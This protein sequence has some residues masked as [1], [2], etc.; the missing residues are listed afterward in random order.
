MRKQSKTTLG[1]S[2]LLSLVLA[3][4]AAHSSSAADTFKIGYCV[5]IT[6]SVAK[7]GAA[8]IRGS[9]LAIEEINGAGGVA[10][11][12]LELLTEDSKCVPTEGINVASRFVDKDKVDVLMGEVCSSTTIAILEV[13]KRTKVPLVVTT[14]TAPEITAPD[15]P[16]KGYV[17]RLVPT[18]DLLT[19]QLAETVI[20]RLKF[21]QIATVTD[22]GNEWSVTLT[23]LFKEQMEKRGLKPVT[24]ESIQPGETD[25]Y[26]VVSKVKAAKPDAVFASLQGVELVNFTRQAHEAGLETQ[27]FSA[28]AASDPATVDAMGE[29][30]DGMICLSFYEPSNLDNPVSVKFTES[31]RNKY[32]DIEP[33]IYDA[34]AYDGVYC[35]ADVL[36]RTGGDKSKFLEALKDTKDLQ[37]VIGKTTFD[38][39][40]QAHKRVLMVRIEGGMKKIME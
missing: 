34:Q 36:R 13:I 17:F 37:G 31:F 2:V 7:L 26:S 14:S 35:I 6:G 9:T 24:E 12:K 25:F 8:N 16:T 30:A 33:G 39:N 5:P 15:A 18:N 20:D 29:A 21:K 32:P 10:G 11:M 4:A 23:K 22:V 27:L 38:E 1:L 40:G 3:F 19:D 28:Q